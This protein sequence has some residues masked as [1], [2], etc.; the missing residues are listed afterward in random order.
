MIRVRERDKEKRG[1]E[2]K[3]SVYK[4]ERIEKEENKVKGENGKAKGTID[5]EK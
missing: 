4:E 3:E 1:E 5:E 2:G